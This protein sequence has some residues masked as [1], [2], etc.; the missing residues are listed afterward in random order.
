MK[1]WITVMGL[2]MTLLISGCSSPKTPFEIKD[3]TVQKM[4][5]KMDKQESFLF[6]V[7]REN[8]PYCEQLEEYIEKSKQEHPELVIYRLDATDFELYKENDEATQLH[9]KAQQGIEFL[10]L[11]PFFFYTP[12]FYAVEDGVIRSSAVGFEPDTLVVN[13][14]E[15]LDQ[16]VDFDKAEKEDVWDYIEAHA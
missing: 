11:A 4:K 12:T 9:A 7:V 5:E 1:K 15:R 2:V 8:C 6:V 10:D 3:I 14:W 16:V 13:V